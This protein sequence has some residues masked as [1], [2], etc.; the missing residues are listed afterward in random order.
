MMKTFED[1]K[2]RKGILP[3]SW[4]DFHSLCKS[5]ALA[6]SGYH[7]QI[8]L[9]IARGGL[10][11]GT[12]IAHFL[13]VELYPVRLTRRLNDIPTYKEPRWLIDPPDLVKNK[14]VLVVDEICSSGETIRMV[15][16]KLS[17]LEAHA[18]KSAVLY[19]HRSGIA[20][21][22]YIGIITD[23]L[24]LNPWDREIL[25]KDKFDFHPEYRQALK[26]QNISFKSS[27]LIRTDQIKLA[28]GG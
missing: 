12:L 2:N 5:I 22:E 13:Q 8:I 24:I 6:V 19:S 1:Y 11:P 3:V 25:I 18:V 10:Y 20:T 15:K 21:P 4:R 17:L 27:L 23:A 14:K 16:E 7:P 26:L 28:K 9:A